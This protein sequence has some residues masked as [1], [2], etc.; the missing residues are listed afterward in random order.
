M[1]TALGVCALGLELGEDFY[2]DCGMFEDDVVPLN[3]PAMVYS[4]SVATRPYYLVKGPDILSLSVDASQTDIG[5]GIGVTVVAS[6]S[7]RLNSLTDEG[8]PEIPVQGVAKVQLYFD[9]HPDDYAEGDLAWEMESVEIDDERHTF[10]LDIQSMVGTASGRHVFY[11]QATNGDG[12]PGPVS[13]TFF[14]VVR[15]ETPAPT[16]EPTVSPTRRPTNQVRL[17]AS[18]CSGISHSQFAS[19]H[20]IAF[21]ITLE[22]TCDCR[23]NRCAHSG[24]QFLQR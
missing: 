2:E 10:E 16:K 8:Y 14:D 11:A 22:S 15:A 7:L 13:S 9:V 12:Y 24:C 6:D 20:C 19:H 21:T 23:A 1:Y 3:L 4:V 17:S 5:G 18:S